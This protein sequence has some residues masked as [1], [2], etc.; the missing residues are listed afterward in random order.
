MPADLKQGSMTLS[1]DMDEDLEYQ[2]AE[3]GDGIA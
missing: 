3:N 1:I 2:D